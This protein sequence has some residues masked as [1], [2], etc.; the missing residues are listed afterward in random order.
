M[1]KLTLSNLSREALDKTQENLITGGGLPHCVCA[2]ICGSCT[3]YD[4]GNAFLESFYN[5]G[6]DAEAGFY[7]DLGADRAD[8]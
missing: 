1:K 2:H 8:N 7:A 3:C 4:M 6:M 5:N